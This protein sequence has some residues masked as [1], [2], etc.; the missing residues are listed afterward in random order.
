MNAGRLPWEG[1]ASHAGGV[2]IPIVAS[3]YRNRDNQQ[4]HGSPG[5]YADLT[6]LSLYGQQSL[7]NAKHPIHMR[8]C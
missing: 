4:P 1:P 5:S 3:C 6:H 2:E 7:L 8:Y